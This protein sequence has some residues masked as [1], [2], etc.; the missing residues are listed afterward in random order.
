MGDSG[1]STLKVKNCSVSNSSGTNGWMA[2]GAA[3]AGRSP[4][5]APSCSLRCSRAKSMSISRRNS[6]S[7][8]DS[9][10]RLVDLTDSIPCT[11]RTASSIGRVMD[12]CIALGE[13]PCQRVITVSDGRSTSGIASISIRGMA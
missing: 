5:T 12:R 2:G 3:L 8:T 13:A 11:L 7:T 6:T 9:P 4:R 1:D 10:A